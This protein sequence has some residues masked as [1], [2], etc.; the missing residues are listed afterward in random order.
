MITALIEA[1]RFCD[2]PANRERLGETRAEVSFINAP[3][4]AVRMSLGGAFDFGHGRVEKTSSQ[5][6]F[7]YDDANDPTPDKAQWVIGNFLQSGTLPDPSVLS[8]SAAA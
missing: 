4:R 7:H 1:C 8:S 2:A 3:I 5:H 6:V